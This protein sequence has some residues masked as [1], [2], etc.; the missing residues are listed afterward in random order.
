MKKSP[1][2]PFSM[3]PKHWSLSG[4]DRL[5]AEAAYTLDGED[6][7][8]RLLEIDYQ[9][10]LTPIDERDF[11]LKKLVLDR[12]WGKITELDYD[13]AVAAIEHP[14]KK[15]P[16]YK[17]ALLEIRFNHGEIEQIDYDKAQV[18][19]Q[20]KDKNSTEYQIAMTNIE[21][22]HGLLNER[23]YSKAIATIKNEPW[24][25]FIEATI[26]Y[27][28]ETGNRFGFEL[29]WN[30]AF[31][32]DLV[33]HGWHG[34]TQADIVDQWFTQTCQDVFNSDSE[35]YDPEGTLSTPTATTRRKTDGDKTEFS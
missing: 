6:L 34:P 10:V 26:E 1:L 8:R 3:N 30:Q 31:V 14:N 24:V 28:T 7:E 13:K 18:E 35:F 19:L 29:D 23:E 4:K 12:K 25:T 16:E 2:I 9:G 5:A 15:S 21:R 11:K 17:K 27:D 20:Y 32:E 22:N 33:R